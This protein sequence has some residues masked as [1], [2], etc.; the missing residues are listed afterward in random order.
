MTEAAKA[1]GPER[2]DAFWGWVA[3]TLAALGA[4]GGFIFGLAGDG[5]PT[6]FWPIVLI[7]ALFVVLLSAFVVSLD[8]VRVALGWRAWLRGTV[9]V[10]LVAI[11]PFAVAAGVFAGYASRHRDPPPVRTSS[12]YAKQL[13]IEMRKLQRAAGA[14]TFVEAATPK[15][16]A[17]EAAGLSTTYARVSSDLRGLHVTG[18]TRAGN[19]RLVQRLAVLGAAYGHLAQVVGARSSSDAE[20]ASARD[21]VSAALNGVRAAE[22]G[23]DRL[24]YRLVLP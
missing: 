8:R 9:P 23:L 17:R 10:L 1:G 3:T 19:D 22:Q 18:P 6:S 11:I 4:L 15:E 12:V 20:T 21:Q 14:A 5:M 7:D 24:G 2:S 16:Y 13:R